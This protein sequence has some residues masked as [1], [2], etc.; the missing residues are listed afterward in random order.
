VVSTPLP[1]S[2]S[3]FQKLVFHAIKILVDR[4]YSRL[5]YPSRDI[6]RCVISKNN[7]PCATI[8][9]S[10]SSVCDAC[11]CAKAHQL[12]SSTSSAPLQLIFSDVWGHAIE[13]FGRKRYYVSFIDDY[14]KLLEYTYSVIN[15]KSISIFLS[16]RPM[17]SACL[18]ARSSLSNPTG[19]GNMS[20]SIPYS[21]KLESLIKCLVLTP[22]N[23]TGLRSASTVI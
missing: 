5:G 8:D 21:A 18:V 1:S 23:K 17:L 20:I 7:L 12:S 16:F 11:A 10:N 13:S 2:S 15:S 14:S 3:K 6:V 9:S 4:W 22:I 19:V